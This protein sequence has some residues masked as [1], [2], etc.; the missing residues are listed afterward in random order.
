[1][2]VAVSF[3]MGCISVDLLHQCFRSGQCGFNGLSDV[4]G[5]SDVDQMW[6]GMGVAVGDH[7]LAEHHVFH[8]N[9]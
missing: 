8:S 1:M 2:S 7:R 6:S 3:V 9:A 5:V 4:V